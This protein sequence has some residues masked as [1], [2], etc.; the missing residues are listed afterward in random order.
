MVDYALQNSEVIRDI[1]E[2]EYV[3]GASHA[4]H[5]PEDVPLA[6]VPLGS[7][8]KVQFWLIEGKD[9][10]FRLV[11]ET[12]KTCKVVN[13][14]PVAGTIDELRAFAKSLKFVQGKA[15]SEAQALGEKI[16]ELDIPRME[17][18]EVRRVKA[19]VREQ[20]LAELMA[21]DSG[22]SMRP[23]RKPIHYARDNFSTDEDEDKSKN[24]RGSD[25]T[26]NS[27]KDTAKTQGGRESRAAARAVRNEETKDGTYEDVS[28]ND[29]TKPSHTI[30]NRKAADTRANDE[31]RTAPTESLRRSSSGRA[32]KPPRSRD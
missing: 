26:T 4:K 2:Q 9:T 11:R 22:Y 31:L 13:W 3:T 6:V 12:D 21:Q 20:R 25:A 5:R 28:E 7:I 18:I 30:E 8:E 23:R 1:I 14:E 10:R 32:I 29:R 19:K 24:T 16:L 17:Q 15:R 27:V